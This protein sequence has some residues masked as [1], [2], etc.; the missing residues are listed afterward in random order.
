MCHLRS[1]AETPARTPDAIAELPAGHPARR[2]R[3]LHLA[4]LTASRRLHRAAIH[5]Q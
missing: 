4:L 5:R 3:R 2:L 1:T